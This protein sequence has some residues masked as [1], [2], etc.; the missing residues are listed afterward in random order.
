LLGEAFESEARIHRVER[1][2]TEV[3]VLDPTRR[4]LF[5]RAASEFTAEAAG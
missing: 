3:F 4:C 1:E 2:E 5:E